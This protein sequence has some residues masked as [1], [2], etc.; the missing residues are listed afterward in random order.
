MGVSLTKGQTISLTKQAN[1]KLTEVVVGLGWQAANPKSNKEVAS[2]EGTE[3]NLF[4]RLAKKV[5]GYVSDEIETAKVV[6]IDCD[7]VAYVVDSDNNIDMVYFGDK[8]HSSGCI[9]HMGD[10]LVGSNEADAEKH[11]EAEQIVMD[12]E[13]LSSKYKEIVVGVNVFRA[14]EKKQ[15]FGMI[16]NSFI[17]ITDSKTH[18]VLCEFDLSSEGYNDMT[19]MVFGKLV[20]KDGDWEFKAMGDGYRVRDLDELKYKVQ[21]SA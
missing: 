14:Y 6:D 21:Y 5:K 16:D 11:V 15:H 1:D 7:A 18:K 2:T 4:K 19:G 8:K 3:T 20:R 13:N 12:L 9:T 17:R 10:N